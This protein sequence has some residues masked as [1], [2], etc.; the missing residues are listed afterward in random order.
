VL[1][2]NDKT[3]SFNV[4]KDFVKSGGTGETAKQ[5]SYSGLQVQNYKS[6]PTKIL[7]YMSGGNFP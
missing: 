5:N 2:Y 1:F 3:I 6:K 4:G 7:L